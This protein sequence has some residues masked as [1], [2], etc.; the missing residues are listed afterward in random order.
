VSKHAN[1]DLRDSDYN[2]TN[3]VLTHTT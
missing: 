3:G 2:K 1:C